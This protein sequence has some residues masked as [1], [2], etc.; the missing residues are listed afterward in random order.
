MGSSRQLIWPLTNYGS[1]SLKEAYVFKQ[2]NSPKFDWV[3]TIWSPDIPPS[4]SLLAWRIMHHK[5]L[6]DDQ[7]QKRGFFMPFMCSLCRCQIES[8]Q[9][10]FFYRII[11]SKFWHWLCNRHELNI[12]FHSVDALMKFCNRPKSQCPI[13]VKVSIIFLI[14]NI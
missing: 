8:I 7:L 1:M 6:T 10:L 2:R 11:A 4:K 5:I 9:H 3:K 12:R 13:I 14:S